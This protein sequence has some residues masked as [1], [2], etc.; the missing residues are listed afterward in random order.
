MAMPH[1]PCRRG[2][3]T[4]RRR[5]VPSALVGGMSPTG[6][7]VGVPAPPE[8]QRAVPHLRAPGALSAVQHDLSLLPW[9]VTPYR[10]D[11]TDVVG[12]ALELLRSRGERPR[13]RL[14][15]PS[16]PVPPWL[17]AWRLL[18]ALPTPSFSYTLRVHRQQLGTLDVDPGEGLV[19]RLLAQRPG[20]TQ[21]TLRHDAVGSRPHTRITSRSPHGREFEVRSSSGAGDAEKTIIGH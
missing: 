14:G 8:R 11:T 19:R 16:R 3:A 18:P 12:Q 4:D 10:C 9:F 2:Q 17:R 5:I 21:M 7:L 20:I 6:P 15:P 1:R 13:V